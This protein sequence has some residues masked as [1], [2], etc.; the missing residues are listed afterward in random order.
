MTQPALKPLASTRPRLT[1][2]SVKTGKLDVPLR[3]LGYGPEGVG[4]STFASHAPSPIFL[5]AENGTEALDIARFPEPETWDDALAC[6]DLLEKESHAYKTIVV[7]PI[8]WLEP[9]VFAKVTGGTK[10]IEEYGGGFGKGYTAAVDQWRV[11][12]AALERLWSRGMHVVLLA[13]A[14][15]KSFND[16]EGPAYDRYEI[17]MNTKAAGLLKQWSAY[18][19]FMRHESFSKKGDDKKAKGFSTGARVMH[20]QWTAAYDAK[21]R[22][23]LPD[24]LPLS[25]A[26]FEGAIARAS[27]ESKALRERIA[28]LV[29]AI[30]D[31][32]VKAKAAGYVAAA[33]D[34]VG[35][36]ATIA[37]RLAMKANELG[38]GLKEGTGNG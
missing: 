32:G 20:T 34:D 3:I 18:V 28:T 19:L 23:L 27:L 15:V 31:E 22:L 35:Q 17:A 16:P 11:F 36:L 13:H 4:K 24:E 7:D 6:L 37:N 30:G 38:L 12:V 8:N 29:E 21:R 5:G 14:Q 33:G 9:L 10:S 2:A 25:W 26:D 1:L